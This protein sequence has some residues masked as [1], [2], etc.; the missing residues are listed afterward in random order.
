MPRLA[1]F[2]LYNSPAWLKT[3]IDGADVVVIARVLSQQPGADTGGDA[4]PASKEVLT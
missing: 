3:R 1:R 2:L 4:S